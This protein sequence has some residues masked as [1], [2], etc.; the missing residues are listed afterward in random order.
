MF[1]ARDP[2]LASRPPP[3]VTVGFVLLLI[4]FLTSA[5]T[6]TVNAERV[7]DNNRWVRHTLIVQQRVGEVFGDIVDR[8]VWSG[9][10]S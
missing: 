1:R 8:E 4:L 10:F 9:A 5:V 6:S 3:W 7:L 2:N